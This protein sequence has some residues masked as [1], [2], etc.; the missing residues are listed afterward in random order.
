MSLQKLLISKI[1][2]V[3]VIQVGES[4]INV[5]NKKAESKKPSG[6]GAN[7]FETNE[8]G[9]NKTVDLGAGARKYKM[10]V[11]V[12]DQSDNDK[13]T[14]ILLTQRYCVIVDKFK[15]KLSVYIDSYETT[16]S[17]AH[18]GV[19]VFTIN[20]TVQDIEKTPIINTTAQLENVV[21]DLEVDLNE[22]SEKFAKS[23]DT[24]ASV[25][26]IDE[27]VDSTTK[28]SGFVDSALDKVERGMQAVFELELISFDFFNGI[29]S[30]ANKIKRLTE[31]LKLIT[32]LPQDF[33]ALML[34]STSSFSKGLIEIFASTTSTGIVVQ[35]LDEFTSEDGVINTTNTALSDLSQIEL[36]ELKKTVQANE[37]L[38]LR[39]AIAEMKQILTREY[40]SKAEFDAQVELCIE[41]LS[42][43]NLSNT[44]IINTRQTIKAFANQKNIKGLIDFEVLIETPLSSIIYGIYGNLDFYIELRDINNFK[45]NDAILGTI[46]VY[47][48]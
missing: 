12:F 11:K 15:G 20:A 32:E 9:E 22:T 5:T 2:D 4:K 34:N 23:I 30:K 42:V 3:R 10:Q 47:N 17:D 1:E 14:N 40:T 44:K 16:E 48:V 43:T 46:K 41:R 13:L 25:P 7:P 45:D 37:L 29:Q 24:V 8:G 6:K 36:N 33:V 27:A 38:N 39:T 31:K 18:V 26:I 28:A 19:A 35:K 21:E